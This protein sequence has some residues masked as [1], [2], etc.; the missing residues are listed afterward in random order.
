MRAMAITTPRFAVGQY[1]VSTT[2]QGEGSLIIV[3]QQARLGVFVAVQGR[4]LIG[5]FSD[6]ASGKDDRRPSF[7]AP[8]TRCRQLGAVIV[9]AWLQRIT[10]QAHTLS[11]RLEGNYSIRASNPGEAVARNHQ[12]AAGRGSSPSSWQS[13]QER[14]GRQAVGGS[15]SWPWPS[16][17][18]HSLRGSTR[19]WQRSPFP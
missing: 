17:A 6:S 5:E 10:H 9:S 13:G 12:A 15:V 2:E 11:R 19:R 7:Q 8:L 3:V 14:P 18:S 4:S 16:P 1:R